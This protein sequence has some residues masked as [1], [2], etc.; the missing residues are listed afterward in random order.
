MVK[1]VTSFLYLLSKLLT[2]WQVQGQM[3]SEGD[4]RTV[5]GHFLPFRAHM[6]A[7]TRLLTSVLL[8]CVFG[9]HFH[10]LTSTK[11]EFDPK[12]PQPSFD[13]VSPERMS[14]KGG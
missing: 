10:G 8:F 2:W 7:V 5:R 13:T 4:D 3:R 14:N 12:N 1:A 11:W 9:S 6:E